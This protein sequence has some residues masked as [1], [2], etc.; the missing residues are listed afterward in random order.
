MSVEDFIL[1]SRMQCIVECK[2]MT[3]ISTKCWA[4]DK[5]Y[6][7]PHAMEQCPVLG[8]IGF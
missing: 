6:F 7:M 8:H 5:G 4:A 3:K 2:L 1:Y